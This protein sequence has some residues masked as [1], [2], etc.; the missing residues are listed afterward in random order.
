MSVDVI[1]PQM[2]ES[3][4]EG[5]LVKWLKQV[6]EKIERDEPLFEISTDK[7]DAEIPSP[8]E[9]ILLEIL[10]PEGETVPINTVV[11]RIAAEEEAGVKPAPAAPAAPE[12]EP[13]SATAQTKPADVTPV[14]GPK[15]AAAPASGRVTPIEEKERAR[16]SPLVRKIAEEHGVD[17]TLVRGTGTG[18]RVTKKDILKY[19]VAKR[20]APL[21]QAAPAV[22]APS[23]PGPPPI[24]F[25]GDERVIRE[26]MS[27]MRKKIAEHMVMSG[28]TSAHVCTVFEVDMSNVVK[29]RDALKAEFE[30]EGVKLT[31]L[32]FIIQAVVRG[33]KEVPIMNASIEGDS[34]LYKRDINIGIAVALDWG[35]IVPVIKHADQ[36]N[37]LGLARAAVDLADRAR[38]K[39][40]SVEEVQDGTF[41]ITNPG[42][43]G[44]LFGAPIISQPQVGIMDVGAI[45]KRPVVVD[46]AIAIRPMVYISLS[47]DHR[48][49]D[50]AVADQF[51]VVVKRDLQKPQKCD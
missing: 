25:A 35:L 47:F 17:P 28:R 31:Y 41:T 34:I 45:T 8:A 2:G 19:I 32:P 43:Y 27:I 15:A 24:T 40:L 11:A 42:V 26:P 23:P 36:M 18:G 7:V 30:R 46:D 20:T 21:T 49:I 5:T 50:G 51:M 13:V 38:T 9:G 37:L 4:A 16:V 39:R 33:L 12:S 1:M 10:V 22:Q 29:R 6:G 14:E 3:V 44:S 48:L